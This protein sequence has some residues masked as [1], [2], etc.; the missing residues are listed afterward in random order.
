MAKHRRPAATK[1]APPAPQQRPTAAK[2]AQEARA[3]VPHAQQ[4][5][6]PVKPPH[7]SAPRPSLA[8]DPW[9][10]VSAL[11]VLPLV[12]HAWGAPL[13]EPVAEDFDFLTHALF[14]PH[15]LL[16]G[17]CSSAFWRP[18]AHQLYYESLGGLIIS[19]PGWI[20]A[21]H[22]TLLALASLLLYRAFRGTVSGPAAAAIA[23]FPL[24]SESTRTL[25]SWPSHFVD[26]GLW[27]F[28]AIAFHET[29]ARRLWTALVALLAA[30]L[31]K[32]VA[33]VTALLLPWIPGIGPR[34]RGERLR[35]SAATLALAGVWAG[36]YLSVRHHA[37][38][39]LPHH[40]ESSAQL[41]ATPILTRLTWATGNSLRALFSLP[42]VAIGRSMP[43]LASAVALLGIAAFVALQRRR[44]P[45]VKES[46]RLGAWGLAWFLAASATLA[47]IY[48]IWAPNRSGYGAL[49]FGAFAVALTEAVHPILLGALVALRLTSFALA[50]GPPTDI[51]NRA[52]QAGAFMDFER[53]V[54]LQRLMRATRLALEHR[55]P[56][57]PHGA[58]V[59]QHYLP[60]MAE[61]AFGGPH[62]LQTWYRDSTLRWVRY[63]DFV[64]HTE[65]P[66]VTIAQFQSGHKPEMALV[67]PEAM[68]E[69]LRAYECIQRFKYDSSLVHVERADS[70]QVDRNAKVFKGEIEGQRAIALVGLDRD[71]EAEGI[72]RNGMQLW[73]ENVYA[74][75]AL[76]VVNYRRGDLTASAALLDSIL[77]MTTTYEAAKRLRQ[78]VAQEATARARL[79]VGP[80]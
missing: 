40:L 16:D 29:A 19:H 59:G 1:A 14:S 66:L 33:V 30:L 6:A 69:F 51:E 71:Q 70:I 22:V 44:S 78:R 32:E 52:P 64:A 72:A 80:R 57:L 21:L 43:I 5:R 45:R 15:T 9:A 28:T 54:R 75:F 42:A 8:R 76:A 39:A 10:W 17:G 38:L 35:W 24:L 73:R 13:G 25:I 12:A 18:V 7:G 63:A 48:P 20:A 67:E 34:G 27:L 62:A 60:R 65:M 23:T 11:A 53:L 36:A 55:Y 56:T 50:P 79:R 3:P 31:C 77:R 68:R 61:Y 49:G 41:A 37:H 74:E 2:P 46:L 47:S 26:L 58:Q 4:P